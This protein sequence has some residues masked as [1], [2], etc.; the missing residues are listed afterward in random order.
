MFFITNTLQ[1]RAVKE[2]RVM[3]ADT[4]DVKKRSSRSRR[5]K[6]FVTRA[7]AGAVINISSLLKRSQRSMRS[8]IECSKMLDRSQR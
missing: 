6:P 2:G 1:L 7:A 4:A 8:K 5:P 3:E